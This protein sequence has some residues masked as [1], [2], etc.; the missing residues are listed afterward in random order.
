M[1]HTAAMEAVPCPGSRRTV[2]G[3]RGICG[4]HPPQTYKEH[5]GRCSNTRAPHSGP[6]RT[7]VGGEHSRGFGSLA[8]STHMNIF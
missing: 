5:I 4:K 7:G 6:P 3:S 2:S 8:V 1:G